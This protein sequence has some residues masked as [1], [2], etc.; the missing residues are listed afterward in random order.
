MPQPLEIIK[1]VIKTVE[2]PVEKI[3]ERIIEK[4]VEVIKTVEVPVEVIKEVEKIVEVPV[5]VVKE[6]PATAE[7]AEEV[8]RLLAELAGKN[9]ELQ[10]R[11]TKESI[12]DQLSA[13]PD[14]TG[15]FN[16]RGSATFGTAWPANPVR[17]D[18]FL[19]VDIKPN[20]LYKWNGRK[21]MEIDRQRIDDTLVYDAT[22]IDW[23]ID[24]VRRGHK[25]YD[26]LTDLEKKQI[27]AR[28]K[29]RKQ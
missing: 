18:L 23:L 24:Q 14:V 13:Q 8:N 2:V 1:E 19:K 12:M 26:D 27:A 5:E 11:T 28:I 3:V 17:G 7:L 29:Q 9:K 25:D 4:P 6:D 22:Y 21:W 20:Q 16:E 10:F 15:L